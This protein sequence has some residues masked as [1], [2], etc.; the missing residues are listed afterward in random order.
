[1][2]KVAK[3]TE[4]QT[5]TFPMDDAKYSKETEM[6]R[7]SCNMIEDDLILCLEPPKIIY[8]T[9]TNEILTICWETNTAPPS[10]SFLAMLSILRAV[11]KYLSHRQP[12]FNLSNLDMAFPL[13]V[14]PYV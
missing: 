11:P 8:Y 7:S 13:H 1:M 14:L 3:V 2:S 12:I 10:Q 4:P 5:Q 6:D 9:I